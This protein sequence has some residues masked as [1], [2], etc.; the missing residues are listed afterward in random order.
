M[1]VFASLLSRSPDNFLDYAKLH[2]AF[3]M[4]LN[5]VQAGLM[6]EAGQMLAAQYKKPTRL[7]S[8]LIAPPHSM[9]GEYLFLRNLCSDLSDRDNAEQLDKAFEKF[10]DSYVRSGKWDF[11]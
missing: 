9:I 4:Q 8:G 11:S 7:E 10:S 2:T 6:S 3:N 5:V 1:A